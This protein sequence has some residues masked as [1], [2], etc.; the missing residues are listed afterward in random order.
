MAEK[1]DKRAISALQRIK[2][3]DGDVARREKAAAL[4]ADLQKSVEGV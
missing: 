1:G 2:G 3:F 4:L